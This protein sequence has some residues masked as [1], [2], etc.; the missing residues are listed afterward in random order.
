MNPTV[1]L[2]GSM[3][4]M[5]IR[6]SSGSRSPQSPEGL[7]LHL[8]NRFSVATAGS[9]RIAGNALR[10]KV[11]AFFAGLPARCRT[12]GLCS[13]VFVRPSLGRTAPAKNV[14]LTD[15]KRPSIAANRSVIVRRSCSCPW[16]CRLIGSRPVIHV[17]RP[18]QLRKAY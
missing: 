11:R 17:S 18:P 5:G 1:A 10:L 9:R 16:T 14:S 2:P 13:S 6:L 12:Y 15:C 3:T 4:W 8:L 7:P